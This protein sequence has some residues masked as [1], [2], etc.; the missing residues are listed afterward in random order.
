M[1]QSVHISPVET[2]ETN[3]AIIYLHKWSYLYGTRW[4]I[5]GNKIIRE[6]AVQTTQV[7]WKWNNVHQEEEKWVLRRCNNLQIG[8]LFRNPQEVLYC[9]QK[10][11]IP[12]KCGTCYMYMHTAAKALNFTY[13]HEWYTCI[14]LEVCPPCT[15]SLSQIWHRI[16]PSHLKST[17][18][19]AE[20]V[21]C[22][23]F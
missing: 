8:T 23:Y 3:S 6:L 4:E 20:L 13:F 2:S 5:L 14:R 16:M 10:A 17:Y 21:H 22:V 9:L 11:L 7:Q 19:L 15:S 12:R 1:V 18:S